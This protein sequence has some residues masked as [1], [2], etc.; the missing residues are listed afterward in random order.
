MRRC[1]HALLTALA[2]ALAA[3]DPAPEPD[4]DNDGYPAGADC[5]DTDPSVHPGADERCDGVDDDCNG[6]ID[7]DAWDALAWFRDADGDGY[8][9]PEG[10]TYACTQPTDATAEASDCDDADPGVHPAATETCDGRDEDCDGEVDE[11]ATDAPAWFPDADGDGYGDGA[12]PVS[13][14]TQPSG[15]LSDG[16][17]CQDTDAT[18]HPGA[19]EICDGVDQDC[20]GTVDEEVCALACDA[21]VPASAS[22]LQDAAD[23]VADGATIC[24]APGTWTGTTLLTG[25]SLAIVGVDG[26]ELTILDGGGAG[27]VLEVEGAATD[28]VSLRGF[29]LTGGSASDGGALAINGATVEAWDLILTANSAH[30]GG[31]LALS[32]RAHLTA[33]NLAVHGNLAYYGGGV[34]VED[35]S[36]LSATALILM[37]NEADAGAGAG[38]CARGGADITLAD[39]TVE[40]NVLSGTATGLGGAGLHVDDSAIELDGVTIADNDAGSASGGGLWIGGTSAA[41]LQDVAIDSNLAGSACRGGGLTLTDTATLAL[42][43]VTVT[44]NVCDGQGGGLFLDAGTATTGRGVAVADHEGSAMGGGIYVAGTLDLEGA[45]LSGQVA[46]NGGA[47]YAASGAQVTLR[48]SALVGNTVSRFGGGLYAAESDILL[49]N[50]LAAANAAPGSQGGGLYIDVANLT[51]RNLLLLQNSA[52]FDAGIFLWDGDHL[53]EHVTAVGNRSDED[54]GVLGISSATVGATVILRDSILAANDAGTSCV[55]CAVGGYDVT[56]TDT[57]LWANSPADIRWWNDPISTDDALLVDP[58]LLDIS[59]A[60]WEDWDL[61]LTAGSP[62]VDAGGPSAL[63]PDGSPADL[64]VFGGPGAAGWDLDGDGYPLW[65]QPGPYDSHS[66]PAAGWD[67]DDLD[68]TILPG[69]GC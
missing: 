6:E 18:I 44:R 54:G 51:A 17:D 69:A 15:L 55:I 67:C 19:E 52:R 48:S 62:G 36:S 61:H 35:D 66:Y 45:A 65:W 4:L 37:D 59:A 63:D 32:G 27:P 43:E 23:G 33:D 53:L 39:A 2:L 26:A 47:I 25:R 24:I 30:H 14:C 21:W 3:C 20:D 13:A 60:S 50:V 7:D 9:D 22:S 28:S 10:A 49:E 34:Y 16:A 57:V 41:T 8:G 56:I 12:A 38:L 46:L 58:E 31:G 40:R 64:G 5:D 1:S 68:P 29:T 42:Q 11:E